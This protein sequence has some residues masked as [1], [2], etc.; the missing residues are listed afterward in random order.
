MLQ[1]VIVIADQMH[2]GKSTIAKHLE[3]KY[4]FERFALA[5]TIKEMTVALLLECGY[6]HKDAIDRCFGDKK[7]LPIE[8]LSTPQNPITAR[9][10]LQYTGTEYRDALFDPEVWLRILEN[11][12][13]DK[14]KICIDDVRYVHEIEFFQKQGHEVKVI[15]VIRPDLSP[16]DFSLQH[17]SEGGLVGFA[18][19]A[20]LVNDDTIENLQQKV[21][22]E[23]EKFF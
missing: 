10:V 17:A 13:K 4:G 21:D 8:I 15:R 18:A 9:R 1:I 19:D 7:E 12:A 20:T 2:S 11:K 14:N 3:A 6:S 22:R 16:L 23:M 5:Y